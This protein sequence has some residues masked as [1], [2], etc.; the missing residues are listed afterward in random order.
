MLNCVLTCVCCCVVLCCGVARIEILCQDPDDASS[1]A[2]VNAE[3]DGFKKGVL[4]ILYATDENAE[5]QGPEDAAAA[6]AA[7]AAAEDDEAEQLEPAGDEGLLGSD[8]LHTE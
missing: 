1:T 6:A 5:F 8:E 4:A 7:P 2:E 3:V